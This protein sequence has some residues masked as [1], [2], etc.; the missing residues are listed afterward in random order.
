MKEG[1]AVF[2]TDISK[3]LLGQSNEWM[4]ETC[5][6][7]GVDAVLSVEEAKGPVDIE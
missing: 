6:L 5:C 3:N 4:S 2:S 1:A 7:P